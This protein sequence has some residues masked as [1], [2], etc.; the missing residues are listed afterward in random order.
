MA[1]RDKLPLDTSHGASRVNRAQ[2]ITI[3]LQTAEQRLADG[4][5]TRKVMTRSTTIT[6][7]GMR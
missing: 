3:L 5:R 7:G 2:A 4:N 6:I 1:S